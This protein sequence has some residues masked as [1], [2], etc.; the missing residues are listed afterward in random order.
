MLCA[1]PSCIGA[2]T[3]V[4]YCHSKSKELGVNV[5][6]CLPILQKPLYILAVQIPALKYCTNITAKGYRGSESSET[7]HYKADKSYGTSSQPLI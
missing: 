1:T 7:K 2:V 6:W 3:L 4:C 5:K